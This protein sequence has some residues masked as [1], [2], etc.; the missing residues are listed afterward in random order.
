[1]YEK[2]RDVSDFFIMCYCNTFSVVLSNM[3][4]TCSHKDHIGSDGR[5]LESLRDCHSLTVR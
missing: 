5:V 2:Y 1:M 3:V 4:L